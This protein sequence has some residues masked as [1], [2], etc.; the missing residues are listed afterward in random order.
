MGGCLIGLLAAVCLCGTLLLYPRQTEDPAQR[1]DM[2]A[3]Q[4]AALG[5]TPDEEPEEEEEDQQLLQR[6][7]IWIV[8]LDNVYG[9]LNQFTI[10]ALLCASVMILEVD[11]G[12]SFVGAGI[13]VSASGLA[14]FPGRA[15]FEFVLKRLGTKREVRCTS[16]FAV[17]ASLLFFSWPCAL[18]GGG[19]LLCAG[20]ILLGDA[21][22]FSALNTGAAIAKGIGSKH[23]QHRGFWRFENNTFIRICFTHSL[24]TFA[25][26]LTRWNIAQGGRDF[27][28]W[29]QVALTSGLVLSSE[30]IY[31]LDLR[32]D[33]ISASLRRKVRKKQG[34]EEG[35]SARQ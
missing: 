35:R 22:L 8:W 14:V 30:L 29:Q 16:S 31:Y 10:I 9:I 13:A 12:W 19:E 27:Y 20:T 21:L 5:R 7:Q 11:L 32:C 23:Q 4:D 3:L 1:P 15:A 26:V 33:G 34:K 25:P 28:A 17:L 6:S 24:A 2:L 18:G